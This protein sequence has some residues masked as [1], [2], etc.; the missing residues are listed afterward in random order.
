[1]TTLKIVASLAIML[2]VT[3]AAPALPK[4]VAQVSSQTSS[5]VSTYTAPISVGV[6]ATAKQSANLQTQTNARAQTDTNVAANSNPSVNAN[7]NA[8]TTANLSATARTAT[9]NQ[10]AAQIAAKFKVSASQVIELQNAGWS[11]E[12]IAKLYVLAKLSG[13][14]AADIKT[15]RAN[16]MTWDAIEFRLHLPPGSAEVS[17]DSIFSLGAVGQ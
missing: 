6:Q 8:D 11:A 2:A 13:K 14:F 9:Q 16:G 17:L 15:M 12:D 1:M 7:A 5:Q 4:L 10:L 3:I